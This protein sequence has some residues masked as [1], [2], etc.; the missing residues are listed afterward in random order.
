EHWTKFEPN[1][2]F[3]G[4]G[5][6]FDAVGVT[7]PV[8]FVDADGTW[9]MYYNGIGEAG[10]VFGTG[11]G[12]ATAASPEGP[13]EREDDPV[14][15]SGAARA[16]DA[17][18]LFPDSVV[19][20]G[21]QYVMYYSSGFSVGRATSEDGITWTKDADPVLTPA[22]GQWDSAIAWG[23]DVRLTDN[24]WEMFY[25]GAKTRNGGP[26]I[27]VGYASSSDGIHWERSPESVINLSRDQAFFPTFM[28]EPDGTY[29]VYYAV[30][31]NSAYTEF[32][33]AMGTITR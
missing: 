10:Q 17:G 2:V 8:V 22:S 30:A 3:S 14:L 7:R 18:F 20:D 29:R 31:S 5:S 11:I 32:H 21:D 25:Y 13:W 12:R 1:P 27:D 33:L 28:V 19:Q 6:G 16:W 15:E 24:G 26:G 23:S 9:V 4:D